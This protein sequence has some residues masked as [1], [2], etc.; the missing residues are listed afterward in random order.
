MTTRLYVLGRG[1]DDLAA[2][3]VVVL[4][5]PPGYVLFRHAH[6]C[7]RFEVVV[8]GSMTAD[9]EVLGP[10][11]VMTAAPGEFYGPHVAGPEGCTTVEVFGTLDGVFRV[12]AESGSGPKEYDFRTAELPPEYLPIV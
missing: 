5:M 8:K 6:V 12:L 9:G 4:E 2:P 10:G 1:G 3:A 7:H 11:D